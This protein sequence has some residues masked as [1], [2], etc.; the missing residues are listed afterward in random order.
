MR[1]TKNQPQ[2]LLPRAV[3][4]GGSPARPPMEGAAAPDLA[5]LGLLDDETPEETAVR[6]RP[7]ELGAEDES[8]DAVELDLAGLTVFPNRRPCRR[9][10]FGSSRISRTAAATHVGALLP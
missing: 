8:A 9:S 6:P 4:S 7:V 5:V 2:H 1:S 3:K 10:R